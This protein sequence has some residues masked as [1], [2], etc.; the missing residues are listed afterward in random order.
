MLYVS[1]SCRRITGYGPEVFFKDP[2]RLEKIIL[3]DDVHLWKYH[4]SKVAANLG[5]EMLQFRIK[6]KDNEIRWIDHICQP[7][8]DEDGIFLGI[9]ASNRDITERKMIEEDLIKN[10]DVLSE[11]QQIAHLGNWEWDIVGNDLHWSDEVYRIFGVSPQAFGATYD[12]FLGYIHPDDRQDVEAAVN[13]SLEDPS[14]EYNIQHRVIR[15]DRSVRIVRERGNV[16][17]N[18]SGEPVRMIGTVQDITDT[19]IMED[20]TKRLSADMARMDRVST[21]NVLAGGI[22]HEINQPLAAIMT[23]AQAG[24]RLFSDYRRI[25]DVRE[26]LGDIVEDCRRAGGVIN[27]MR[28]MIGKREMEHEDVYVNPIIR[29]VISMLQGE[30]I[31]RKITL[32]TD[33]EPDIPPIKGDR[34]NLQQVILNLFM[35]AFDALSDKAP[36]NRRMLIKSCTDGDKA[37]TVCVRDW[38]KGF[39]SGEIDTIFK[40]FHSTKTEG[41]GLGLSICK[42]IIDAHGGT[43]EAENF[44]EMGG[45][46]IFTL[47]T[48]TN[49]YA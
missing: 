9:R 16:A 37:V 47:P 30:I 31:L 46:V 45:A 13:R 33:F 17:F 48:G 23:N 5:V 34:I 18:E 14:E 19:K 27:S 11:A 20:E 1:P 32:M 39:P 22:A 25:D 44:P 38:G 3:P 28:K 49:N 7:T 21:M 2:A 4:E 26:V 29:E 10:R 24:L 8:Y 43:I 6:T 36:E 42:S 40:S 15:S 41:L 35:N 12:A